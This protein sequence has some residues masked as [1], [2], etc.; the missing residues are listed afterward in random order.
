MATQWACS[1]TWDMNKVIRKINTTNQSHLVMSNSSQPH[2]PARFIYPCKSPGKNT[3]VGSQSLLEGI[4]QTQGLNLGLLHCRQ[5]LYCLNHHRSAR[6][7]LRSNALTNTG[8]KKPHLPGK[9]PVSVG[10]TLS[11]SSSSYCFVPWD[12]KHRKEGRLFN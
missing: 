9:N 1:N 2:E 12:S 3:G 4:F 7:C 11:I 6:E 5:I 8:S 10:S